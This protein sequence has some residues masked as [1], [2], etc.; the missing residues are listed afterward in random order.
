MTGIYPHVQHLL[1]LTHVQHILVLNEAVL[2]ALE[3]SLPIAYRS[4]RIPFSHLSNVLHSTSR[5]SHDLQVLLF[6]QTSF[7]KGIYGQL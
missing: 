1:T 4:P 5:L 7:L 6:Y 3:G 2:W